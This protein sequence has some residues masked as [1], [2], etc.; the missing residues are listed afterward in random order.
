MAQYVDA[1]FCMPVDLHRRTDLYGL[2]AKGG[3]SVGDE[4]LDKETFVFGHLNISGQCVVFQSRLSI[5]LVNRK[6]G[7]M[8]F[9]SGHKIIVLQLYF[10]SVTPG[11]LLVIPKRRAKRMENLW[12]D[13]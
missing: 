13:E 1:G 4:A 12:P 10:F 11:H 9:S 7:K 2:A 8:F 5:V 6:P 3:F